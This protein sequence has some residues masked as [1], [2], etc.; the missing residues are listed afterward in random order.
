MVLVQRETDLG[1]LGAVAELDCAAAIRLGD[2]AGLFR[3]AFSVRFSPASFPL[4]A[5][6]QAYLTCQN[7]VEAAPAAEVSLET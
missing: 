1:L 7:T 4:K 6:V 2:M 3:W 5:N